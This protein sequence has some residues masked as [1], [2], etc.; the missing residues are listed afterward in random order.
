MDKKKI[1]KRVETCDNE[2]S[3]KVY[4]LPMELQTEG[5]NTMIGCEYRPQSILG[6]ITDIGNSN[7]KIVQIGL[8]MN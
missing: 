6:N 3:K 5:V 1:D 4:C 2:S 7:G 8:Q